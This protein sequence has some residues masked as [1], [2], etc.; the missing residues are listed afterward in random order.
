[1]GLP[2]GE[3]EDVPGLSGIGRTGT[4]HRKPNELELVPLPE[5]AQLQFLP[6]RRAVG[7][8]KRGNQVALDGLA[9]AA[10]LPI[11]YTRTMMPAFV[12]TR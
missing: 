2:G 3:V 4:T 9:V 8:D 7:F 10:R 1:M 6:G 12:S 11:G 5:E